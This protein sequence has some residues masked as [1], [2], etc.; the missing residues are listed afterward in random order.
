MRPVTRLLTAWLATA[1]AA[2]AA[3]AHGGSF[4]PAQPSPPDPGPPLGPGWHTP[5]ITGD[6]SLT[7]GTSDPAVVITRWEA[8][9]SANK[10]GILRLAE[11]MRGSAPGTTESRPKSER[12]RNW[13][14]LR[15]AARTKRLAELFVEALSDPDSE[16][17][18]AAAIALGKTGCPEG[19]EPLR[20]AALK[21]ARK[22]VRESAVL[23][24]G[25]L[26]RQADLPF[27]EVLLGQD[28]KEPR[29]RA[30]A[31]FS[32]GMIGGE[33]AAVPL[34]RLADDG[35]EERGRGPLLR[36]P[37]LA[38]SVFT[39]MGLCGSPAA[40]P[41]LRRAVLDD[42]FD[43]SV[44]AFA[45]VALGRLGDR[46]SAA[47]A[48]SILAKERDPSLRRAAAIALGKL[49]AGDDAIAVQTLLQAMR[50]ERDALARHFAAMALGGIDSLAVRQ[51]LRAAFKD[52]ADSDRP[53]AALALALQRDK[54]SAP[55]LRDALSRTSD[56]SD[57]GNLCIALG[58]LGDADAVPIVEKQM[59]SAHK[60]WLTGYAA[61][62]LGLLG[63]TG[64]AAQIRARL[65]TERDQRLRMN[66]A[67]AL[68]LLHDPAAQKYLVDTLCGAGYLYERG[69]AAMA[70]GAL[71]LA[72]A[73]PQLEA[74][75]RDRNEK[76]M[77]RAFAVIALG[78][79]AD[80]S[81]VPKLARFAIDGDYGASAKV[82]PLRELLSIY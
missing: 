10:E 36:Q 46:V 6:P 74:V 73:V 34:L 51:E 30:F 23:G 17:R 62:A 49:A 15:D 40:L 57:A 8:W 3:Y 27:L 2:T 56:E 80:P 77:L 11:R 31:A 1:F 28:E 52:G 78:Q 66:L 81:E 4:T 47:T 67:V 79:I 22:D 18:T 37:E 13:E 41:A 64:S 5:D 35:G 45:L 69:S 82:D 43:P 53:F 68:G 50:G 14:R 29:V 33:D 65:E 9:W 61:L 39:A 20:R 24:L 42:R 55:M 21:D 63:S 75:Y 58:V 7:P 59:A 48:V 16:V 44:R 32:M 72:P 60:P 71:R 26:G 38:A 12:E 54:E 19:A 76:E 70:L 25:L